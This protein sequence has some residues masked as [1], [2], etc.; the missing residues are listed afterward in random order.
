MVSYNHPYCI[1]LFLFASNSEV[2]RSPGGPEPLAGAVK[3]RRFGSDHGR[4]VAL[5]SEDS[6]SRRLVPVV[7]CRR[8]SPSAVDGDFG[9]RGVWVQHGR[10]GRRRLKSRYNILSPVRLIAG[11]WP[12]GFINPADLYVNRTF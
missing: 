8:D 9:K 4:F 10:L 2:S 12:G 1:R 3:R 6:L 11:H 5:G 7:L